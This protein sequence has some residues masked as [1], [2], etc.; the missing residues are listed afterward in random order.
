M[1]TTPHEWAAA[2][3]RIRCVLSELTFNYTPPKGHQL[4]VLF[5]V[6]IAQ[7]QLKPKEE[8]VE[9][10][11]LPDVSV[12]LQ[13]L[14]LAEGKLQTSLISYHDHAHLAVPGK[15]P[16]LMYCD[17][18]VE[19]AARHIWHFLTEHKYPKYARE[20][21]QFK[22]YADWHEYPDLKPELH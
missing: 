15:V 21:T 6:G 2:P 17:D 4:V 13:E 11:L 3:E 10:A 20:M 18:D 12:T 9:T 5:P 22:L 8:S 16:F 14:I 1:I 19:A 7:L